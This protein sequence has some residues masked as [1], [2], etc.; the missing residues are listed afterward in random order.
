MLVSARDARI[1]ALTRRAAVL[2]GCPYS[3]F[4]LIDA[5]QQIVRFGSFKLRGS[6]PRELSF[7]T[8]TIA[9]PSGTMVVEDACRH[10]DFANN[11]LVTGAPH[12]RSYAGVSVCAPDGE[13]LG[14][15]CVADI[16]PRRIP[17]AQ[18]EILRRLA[19]ELQG[20]ITETQNA[21]QNRAALDRELRK[22]VTEGATDLHWQPI[23]DAQRLVPLGYEALARWRRDDGSMVPPDQFI[24]RIEAM[25]LGH[26]FEISVLQAACQKALGFPESLYAS[27][28]V[29]ANW[30]QYSQPLLAHFVARELNRL[31]LP[32]ERLTLEI[33]ERVLIHDYDRARNEL[34]QLKALG[35]RLALD[36]FGTGFSSLSYLAQLPFDI[37]KLD[38]SFVT[39]INEDDKSALLVGAMIKLCQALDM[40]VCVEGVEEPRQLQVLQDYGCD[41]VQ[42]YLFGRP[43]PDLQSLGPL[44]Q[45]GAANPMESAR[46][47]AGAGAP[48]PGPVAP[49]NR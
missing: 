43:A 3:M 41:L 30:F 24:P 14:A 49:R 9:Q 25:G 36:D 47:H 2:L 13:R 18:I 10:E 32:P 38:R 7:C 22:A 20:L 15:L 35:V 46:V 6:L 27:V 1:E 40:K 37:V 16:E 33:T 48:S 23:V 28:N 34:R 11:I 26:R 5:D 17:A 44:A 45:A 31:G 19:Q 8:H 4:S 39:R 42:G 12:I 21:A 29:S